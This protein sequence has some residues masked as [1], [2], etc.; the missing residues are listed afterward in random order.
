MNSIHFVSLNWLK[1]LSNDDMS[2]E[3]VIFYHCTKFYFPNSEMLKIQPS[4]SNQICHACSFDYL[5]KFKEMKAPGEPGLDIYP[6]YTVKGK[7]APGHRTWT[8][9]PWIIRAEIYNVFIEAECLPGAWDGG[10]AHQ[11][12]CGVGISAAGRETNLLL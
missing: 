6:R 8:Y 2:R 12:E 4:L 9:R 11:G 7:E 5:K 1:L 3:M 10:S